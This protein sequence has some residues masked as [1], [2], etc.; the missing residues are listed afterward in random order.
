MR[1]RRQLRCFQQRRYRGTTSLTA[2]GAAP[3][4]GEPFRRRP[5]IAA[6]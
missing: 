2:A 3:C 4:E 6:V 5:L 1:G